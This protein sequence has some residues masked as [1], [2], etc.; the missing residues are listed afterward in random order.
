MWRHSKSVD[1]GGGSDG[2]DRMV[3]IWMVVE[4]SELLLGSRRDDTEVD[5]EDEDGCDNSD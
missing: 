3:E 5:D 4:G 1:T 2:M